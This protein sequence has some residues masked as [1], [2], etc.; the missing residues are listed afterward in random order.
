MRPA[1][2]LVATMALAAVAGTA[3][4]L[5]Q[6]SPPMPPRSTQSP[7]SNAT[8]PPTDQ[9]AVA[10]GFAIAADL[11][12]RQLVLFG[13]VDNFVGTWLWDGAKWAQAHPATSP[14]GRYGASAAFDPQI[15]E[16]LLFGGTLM[17][18]QDTGDTWAWDGTTWHEVNMGG[19]GP[20]AGG[21]RSWR[22][23][24]LTPRCCSSLHKEAPGAAVRLGSGTERAGFVIRRAVSERNI[25][26]SWSHSTR[27]RI[28]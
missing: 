22:G 8:I 4:S 18:G 10:F 6:R 1:V 3:I 23:T 11:T 14:P 16:V 9:P 7:P 21:G 19:G 27:Y 24:R 2:V 25:R 12:A 28:R 26:E 5:A 17:T 15:G 13:G 20:T